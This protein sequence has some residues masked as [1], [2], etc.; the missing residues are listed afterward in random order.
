[1]EEIRRKEMQEKPYERG[2][3]VIHTK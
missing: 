1:M 2:D 3:L